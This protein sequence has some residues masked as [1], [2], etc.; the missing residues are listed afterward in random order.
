[1]S[2]TTAAI[3]GTLPAGGHRTYAA[4]PPSGDRAAS[5]RSASG[6]EERWLVVLAQAAPG[7]PD[8]RRAPGIATGASLSSDSTPS[9]AV[10]TVKDLQR[11]A[12]S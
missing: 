5:A 4:A 8:C 1:M 11:P 9:S 7:R 6:T 3:P 10:P 2:S 12:D